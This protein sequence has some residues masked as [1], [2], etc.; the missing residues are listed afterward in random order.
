[1]RRIITHKRE[2]CKWQAEPGEEKDD[3]DFFLLYPS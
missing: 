2:G 1:V 3:S